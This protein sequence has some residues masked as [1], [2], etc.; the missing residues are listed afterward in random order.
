MKNTM[1][2][3]IVFYLV[4]FNI[5]VFAFFYWNNV[6]VQK[7]LIKDFE[8]QYTHSLV[9]QTES[10]L[11]SAYNLAEVLVE[12]LENDED[13]QKA[14]IA[15][16]RQH[17]GNLINPLYHQ[18]QEE[19]DVAQIQFVTADGRS[20]Y[21]AHMPGKFG[22]DL[23]FRKGVTRVIETHEAITVAEPGAAGYGIRRIVPIF[24]G[25]RFVGAFEIGL[26]MEKTIGRSLDKLERGSYA[27]YGLEQGQ[28]QK[29]WGADPAVKLNSGD[30]TE[31]SKGQVYHRRSLDGKQILTLVPIKDID[32]KVIGYIQGEL[33]RDTI[34]AAQKSAKT[35]TLLAMLFSLILLSVLA[36]LVLHRSLRYLNPLKEVIADVSE[37]DLTRV[38]EI[39][40]ND[41]IGE[42]AGDFAQ[43]LDKIKEVF[44]A[45]FS[46][47]SKL[48]SNASFMNDVTDSSVL[49][50]N[51]S[52]QELQ[53][54][55]TDLNSVGQNLQQADQG[56]EEIAG[57]SQ[58]VAKQTQHMQEAY[59]N[60]SM[61]AQSGKENLDQVMQSI[62]KLKD[63][64]DITITRARELEKTSQD[65][66]AITS[67]I[68]AV[69]DQTNLLA[70]NA[71]IEAARA[72]EYGRGFSVV[73]EEVRKL[74]EETAQY[75]KQISELI[76]DVQSNI[77]G[78]VG[79]IESMGV[80]IEEESSTT[81]AVVVNLEEIVQQVIDVEKAVYDI[82]AA[83][84]QQSASSQ[85]ISA[86]VN[87]VT[88]ATSSLLTSLDQTMSN[89]S[90]Q[91]SHFSEL[92]QIAGETNQISESLRAIIQQYRL[93]DEVVLT[94]VK[95]DHVNFIR[96]YEF[97][98]EK[99]LRYDPEEI[100]DHLH[101]RLGKW[102]EGV[103]DEETRALFAQFAA[104]PHEAIHHQARVAVSLNN[105]GR[106][107]EALEVI[108][109][110]YQNSAKIV[111]AIDRIIEHRAM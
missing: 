74:A 11:N 27:I 89:L 88:E 104:E 99:D 4:L 64:G 109:Q 8:E 90:G 62:D 30:I 91:V 51:Q 78:F 7:V 63:S 20:F 12:A 102:L 43:F 48:T 73:A 101:C 15:G 35:R 29:L 38:V 31:L 92:G 19:Y 81:A 23:S 100:A 80:V 37:G 97:I 108:A 42:V 77:S 110:M 52:I 98:V 59:R 75:A 60:L 82:S 26:S 18:W 5:A 55:S 45:L 105:E 9:D 39:S 50:L 95:D 76:A 3:K 103:K 96:K 66:G 1:K 85:E 54:V 56:V 93:P 87:S 107:E 53:G 79:Q 34:L 28:S 40:S 13:I 72:G 49:K 17:L 84:Q 24:D 83:M 86:V 111:E 47:T 57:A 44:Y 70:L 67:T 71:A 10:S 32:G 25:E 33:S 94:Q 65:I 36:F 21:R 6:T 61:M 22:D 68:M 46:N 69:S 2:N 14:F 16:D 41:E 106:H 58:M